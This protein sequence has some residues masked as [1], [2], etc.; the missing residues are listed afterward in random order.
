MERA[1]RSELA[2]WIRLYT[3]RLL[4]VARAFA[5]GADEAEDL[6]QE[7]WIIAFE[8]ARERRP[9][10]PLD[11]WLYIVTVNVGRDRARRRARRQRLRAWWRAEFAHSAGAGP[12]LDV[13]AAL[14]H[15]ALWHC[16][17]ELPR[18]Q[19]EVLLLRVVDD[20]TI[21][22]TASA[23][24]R[25]EGTVKASLHRALSKLRSSL[26]ATQER[27]FNREPDNRSDQPS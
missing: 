10:T 3:P 18:L 14:R 20:L 19:R 27:P 9:G 4:P 11:A 5:D 12:V 24:G 21:A 25:A 16:V 22:D 2:E 6:L 23:L 1:D 8:R 7:V 15:A 13:P 17:A 26:E